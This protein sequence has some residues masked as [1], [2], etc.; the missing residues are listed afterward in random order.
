MQFRNDIQGLRALA[1]LLV[2]I[3]HLNHNWLSG[4]F[5]GVDLFFVISGFLMTSIISSSI[6][7]E[8]FSF[9][10]FYNKRIKRIVPSYIF[11]LLIVALVTPF[12]YL[13][14]DLKFLKAS[15]VKSL[16]FYSNSLFAEGN[17]YFGAKLNENPLLHTWS[18][19][20]EMQ[21]YLILPILMLIFK[22][23]LKLLFTILIVI[24]SIYGSLQID[25]GNKNQMYFSLVARIPEFLIG[26]IFALVYKNG[27]TKNSIINNVVSVVSLIVLLV[28][29]FLISENS[30][31]PGVLALIPTVASAILLAN[32]KTV[33][34]S[35]FSAKP[36]VFIGE[37][38]YSLYLW[39][40]P[41]MAIIRY[42][43][44][45]YEFT[46]S[47]VVFIIILTFVLAIAS[48]YLVE[49]TFRNLKNS[50]FYLTFIPL[51]I[52]S[53]LYSIRI[54]LMFFDKKID[55]I[56]SDRIFGIESHGKNFVQKF[57]DSTKNDKI[58]LF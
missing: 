32:S 39:H 48:Y 40:F 33:I 1:F 49:K 13:F 53:G 45:R 42:K 25:L 17:S 51:F 28:C 56:Y 11:L 16:F 57:G 9:I 5:L 26:G 35:I 2:F 24:L 22:K 10:D 21:F 30:N 8:K 54:P 43:N 50:K 15:F 52:F 37:L 23:H 36:L 4:G 12:F 19:A 34:S 38:S 27:I 3:F 29:S 6:D 47:E 31:F 7:K 18:L 20:I 46:F 55:G 58:F 14:T 41:I 44:D